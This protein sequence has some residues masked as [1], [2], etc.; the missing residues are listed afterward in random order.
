MVVAWAVAPFRGG[1]GCSHGCVPSSWTHADP[2]NDLSFA[3][4]SASLS[5]YGAYGVCPGNPSQKEA[6]KAMG[7]SDPPGTCLRVTGSVL[8]HKNAPASLA[9][10]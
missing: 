7:T 6:S 5:C 4:L 8:L 1:V 3:L 2:L 9:T 10:N